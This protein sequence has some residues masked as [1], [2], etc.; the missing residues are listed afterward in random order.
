[1]QAHYV[2]VICLA[3][4]MAM[5]PRWTKAR[6]ALACRTFLRPDGTKGTWL[7]T[8][9]RPFSGSSSSDGN[10]VARPL[11]PPFLCC[12]SSSTELFCIMMQ[13]AASHGDTSQSVDAAARRSRDALGVGI[14]KV[15]SPSAGSGRGAARAVCQRACPRL[16]CRP[17]GESATPPEAAKRAGCSLRWRLWQAELPQLMKFQKMRAGPSTLK[18]SWDQEAWPKR[19]KQTSLET[20]P[21]WRQKDEG[22]RAWSS[23]SSAAVAGWRPIANVPQMKVQSLNVFLAIALCPFAAPAA[24]SVHCAPKEQLPFPGEEQ[25]EAKAVPR[26]IRGSAGG[27]SSPTQRAKMLSAYNEQAAEWVRDLAQISEFGSYQK[28]L[29]RT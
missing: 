20:S 5:A 18:P 15:G 13:S 2:V 7:L 6:S 26:P 3:T 8:I 10:C 29:T 25:A 17:F 1:M 14:A 23:D 4:A 22:P 16:L 27:P 11:G 28:R 12:T 9:W 21:S 24:Q 19:L